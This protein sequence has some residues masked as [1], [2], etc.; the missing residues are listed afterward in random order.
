M[1]G[2]QANA[3]VSHTPK[4]HPAAIVVLC[5][6]HTIQPN[7][8]R[9]ALHMVR[10]SYLIIASTIHHDF[11][12]SMM[13]K[14]DANDAIQHVDRKRDVFPHGESNPDHVRSLESP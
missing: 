3:T 13:Q 6:T 7:P 5:I 10:H 8:H 11:Y 14:T 1:V 9:S 12:I 4:T 2:M